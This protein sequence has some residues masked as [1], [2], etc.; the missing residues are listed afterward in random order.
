ML[1][2]RDLLDD[3]ESVKSVRSSVEHGISSILGL[4]PPVFFSFLQARQAKAA[5]DGPERDTLLEESGFPGLEAHI[6]EV[7]S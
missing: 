4:R 7:L 1:N 5:P 2:K 6:S 3:E